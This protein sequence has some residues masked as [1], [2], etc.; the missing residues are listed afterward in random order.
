MLINWFTVVA[1]LINF[2]ILVWLLQHFLY[3]PIV[4][5]IDAREKGIAAQLADAKSKVEA[6]Q[7]E[8][9]DFQHKNETFDKDRAAL[10]TKAEG[11]AKTERQRLI[12]QAQKDADALRAKRQQSL[13]TE[14]RNLNQAIVRWTQNQVFAIARKTLADLASTCLEER[15]AD[16]FVAR[17]RALTGAPKDQLASALKAPPQTAIIRC[18]FDLPPA[19]QSFIETAINE[20]FGTKPTI[21]FQTVPELVCGVELSANGQ[22][23]AWSIADYLATLEQ[24]AEKLLNNGAKDDSKPAPPSNKHAPLPLPLAKGELE[25]VPANGTAHPKPQTSPESRKVCAKGDH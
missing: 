21:Q 4:N 17:L 5:A 12:D 14:Q 19:Q 13:Q 15:M 25:G 10:L 11:D 20:T 6:G 7:K 1:Q 2:L 16:V 18:A 24:S 9:D 22:K 23:V 3:K 8:R